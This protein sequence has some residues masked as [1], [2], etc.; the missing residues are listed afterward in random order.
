MGGFRNAKGK[1]VAKSTLFRNL[2]FR[3]FQKRLGIQ[4]IY[5]QAH[6]DA[7]W[8]TAHTQGR[9]WFRCPE[10]VEMAAE[11]EGKQGVLFAALMAG[12]VDGDV[13]FLEALPDGTFGIH[14]YFEHLNIGLKKCYMRMLNISFSDVTNLSILQ[15]KDLQHKNITQKESQGKKLHKDSPPPFPSDPIPS[16]PNPTPLKE[17][18]INTLTFDSLPGIENTPSRKTKSLPAGFYDDFLRLWNETAEV[19]GLEPIPYLPDELK[20]KIRT[21]MKCEQWAGLWQQ[22]MIGLKDLPDFCNPQNGKWKPHFK[23]FIKNGE[24]VAQ[25]IGKLDGRKR[26]GTYANDIPF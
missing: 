11:W 15:Y 21:R 4:R 20:A 7:L 24:S 22:A 14:D 10:E 26:G 12:V 13:G 16:D 6:L 23:W 8:E 5:A 18:C 17:E 3:A 9:P 25:I 19:A 2:K 1:S